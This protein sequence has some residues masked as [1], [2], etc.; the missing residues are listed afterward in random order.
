MKKEKV[1]LIISIVLVIIAII[2]IIGAI[3]KSNINPNV[4]DF[5]NNVNDNQNQEEYVEDEDSQ[6]DIFEPEE[7]IVLEG[8]KEYKGLILSNIEIQLITERECEIRANVRN[9]TGKLIEMQ[10]IK[11]KTY[12]AEGNLLD[13]LGA[14]IDSV[15]AGGYTTLYA[16]VRRRD[17]S[18]IVRVEIEEN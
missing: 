17:V 10:N 9:E 3:V 6:L 11:I 2:L 13:T 15:E 18:N 1:I 16:L 12:D 5:G 14:Q 8:E 7:A 4:D